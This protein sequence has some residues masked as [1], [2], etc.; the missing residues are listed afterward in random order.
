M[1]PLALKVGQL[2][3]LDACEYKVIHESVQRF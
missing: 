2:Y 1:H 3:Y